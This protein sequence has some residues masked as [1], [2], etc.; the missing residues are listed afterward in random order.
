MAQLAAKSASYN[1]RAKP[2]GRVPLFDL[3]ARAKRAIE[4]SARRDQI[5][6]GR[7]RRIRWRFRFV[8][9]TIEPPLCGRLNY[10]V[11]RKDVDPLSCYPP[12]SLLLLLLMVYPRRRRGARNADAAW[13]FSD[14]RTWVKCRRQAK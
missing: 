9:A 7:S 1:A 5:E 8:E 10:S 14:A 11:F 13:T 4:A 6:T 12:P 3:Q 2:L